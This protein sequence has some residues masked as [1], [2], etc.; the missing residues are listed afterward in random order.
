MKLQDILFIL[1]LAFLF[2]KHNPKWFVLAGLVC[3]I[4]SMP[5][6]H[7][8]IFFTAE[9]LVS[10]SVGFLFFAIVLLFHKKN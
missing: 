10:Y 8:W 9:R 1:V 2:Y 5:L 7:F 6:F 3:L 4:L